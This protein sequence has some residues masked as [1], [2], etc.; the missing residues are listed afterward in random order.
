M[1]GG[2]IFDGFTSAE[3]R[4]LE[5]SEGAIVNPYVRVRERR[6]TEHERAPGGL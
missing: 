2:L 1:T 3:Q 4:K 6:E 5:K